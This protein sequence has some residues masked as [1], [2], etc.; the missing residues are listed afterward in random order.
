MR[1]GLNAWKAA[2][3]TVQV[4]SRQPLPLMRQVQITAGALALCGTVAGTMLNPAF[5]IISGF[6]GTGLMFAGILCSSA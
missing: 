4:D 3:Y 6:V 5:Y 1:C 2:V